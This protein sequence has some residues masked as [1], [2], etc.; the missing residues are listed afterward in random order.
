MKIREEEEEEDGSH[1]T[2]LLHILHTIVVATTLRHLVGM[3]LMIFLL[4][5]LFIINLSTSRQAALTRRG[6]TPVH[7]HIPSSPVSCCFVTNSIVNISNTPQKIG[8][9][10]RIQVFPRNL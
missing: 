5:T 6:Y 2:H 10:T 1:D 9:Q 7:A 4:Y 8:I 3:I